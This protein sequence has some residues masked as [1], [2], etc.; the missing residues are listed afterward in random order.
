[1]I[2]LYIF[3]ALSWGLQRG[4]AANAV[5][6]VVALGTPELTSS[7]CRSM[8]SVG[9]RVAVYMCV[10]PCEISRKRYLIVNA[11][12][13]GSFRQICEK[14]FPYRNNLLSRIQVEL[15]LNGFPLD[16]LQLGLPAC[17]PLF[18]L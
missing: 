16:F 13:V 5:W 14:G 18:I 4:S 1:M 7:N 3:V 8:I 10:C 11:D 12:Q 2:F 9:I 6:G 17:L 15:N